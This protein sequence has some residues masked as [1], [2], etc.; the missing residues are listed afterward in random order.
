MTIDN[1]YEYCNKQPEGFP[2]KQNFIGEFQF[3]ET[4]NFDD[5]QKRGKKAE[6]QLQILIKAVEHFKELKKKIQI[7]EKK[8]TKPKEN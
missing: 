5:V 2:S 6:I 7:H 8:M 3:D 4:K 1:L